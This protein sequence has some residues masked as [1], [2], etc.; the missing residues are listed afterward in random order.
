LV[1]GKT[2]DHYQKELTRENRLDYFLL[3]NIKTARNILV[4]EK[5]LTVKIAN[6]LIGK[7]IFVRYLLDRKVK[8]NVKGYLK[9]WSNDGF[10]EV[11]QNISDTRIFLTI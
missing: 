10:C 6:A 3:N 7:C 11:L 1:T 2:W 4:N 5:Q 8:L 9:E